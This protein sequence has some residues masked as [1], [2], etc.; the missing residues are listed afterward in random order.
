MESKRFLAYSRAPLYLALALVLVLATTGA[1]VPAQAQTSPTVYVDQAYADD[2]ESGTP[3]EPYRQFLAGVAGL[4]SGGTI[5]LQP[6]HYAGS[7]ANGATI[8]SKAMTIEAPQGGVILEAFPRMVGKTNCTWGSHDCNPCV[9]DVYT[10]FQSLADH[11]DILGFHL[12]PHIGPDFNLVSCATSPMGFGGSSCQHW[13]GVQRLTADGGR[14][15]VVTRNHVETHIGGQSAFVVVHMGSRDTTGGPYGWNRYTVNHVPPAE[16]TIIDD[17]MISAEHSHPGGIQVMGDILAVGTGE[18]LHFYDLSN[19][20]SPQKYDLTMDRSPKSGSST[21]LAQLQDGRYLLVVT[22]GDAHP[23]D[24][25]VSNEP[26]SIEA[27]FSNFDRWTDPGIGWPAYQSVNLVTECGTGTLYLIG[28]FN[29]GT[30]GLPDPW[31]EDWAD[32]VEIEQYAGT[33]ELQ[34]TR[35]AGLHAYC[36]VDGLWQCNFDAA[37]GIYVDPNGELAIYSTE[38]DDDGPGDTVKFMEFWQGP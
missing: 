17:T 21:A 34:L 19:P 30:W 22:A 16:D 15:M 33:D 24:F 10:S 36:T 6:G 37:A 1:V 38:H 20:Q 26:W 13:Q 18:I 32:L 28:T 5:V 27:G 2:N 7:D 4:T 9:E 12:G 35:W 11:G 29:T 31:G 3:A 23:V 25:Y 8:L 14:W